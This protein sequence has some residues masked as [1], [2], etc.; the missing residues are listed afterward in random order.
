M[1]SKLIFTAAIAY[2]LWLFEAKSQSLN[3][4][5]S[6]TDK[7]EVNNDVQ[8]VSSNG[9]DRLVVVGSGTVNKSVDLKD[10]NSNQKTNEFGFIAV[11]DQDA[12][13]KWMHPAASPNTFTTSAWGVLMNA[14][15][16]VFVYGVYG[17]SNTDFDPGP[18]EVKPAAS[19]YGDVY[20][21]KF[22]SAGVFQ[23]VAQIGNG[24]KPQKM[25]QL[26]NGNLLVSGY[27]LDSAVVTI[28]STPIN[29]KAGIFLAEVSSSGALVKVVSGAAPVPSN[30]SV[31]GLAQD[32]TGNIIIGGSFDSW[33][34][35]DFGPGFSYDTTVTAID[36]F[37][38]KYNSSYEL[39]WQKR[40]GDTLTT[41][42]KGWDR[43]RS[44]VTDASGNIYVNGHFTW[45]TDFDPDANPGVHLLT[46]SRNSPMPNG[47]LMKYNSAGE[48]QWVKQIGRMS[49]TVNNDTYLDHLKLFGG[50]LIMAGTYSNRIDI[51][52]DPVDT[53]VLRAYDG[54]GSALFFAK[55]DTDGKFQEGFSIDDT[56]ASQ[57]AMT[58]ESI[59]GICWLNGKLCAAGLFQ[60]GVDF[61][62]G[63]G[64]RILYCDPTGTLYNFDKD[65]YVA[66]FNFAGGSSGV[67]EI[68]TRNHAL[69]FPNPASDYFKIANENIRPTSVSLL[70][71]DGKLIFELPGNQEV[72]PAEGLKPGIY[73]VLLQTD[74]GMTTHKLI[75]R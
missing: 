13:L 8:G 14:S 49:P 66:S 67:S 63:P 50:N 51:N 72:Y 74:N 62:P 6:I 2:F 29:L 10:P 34:D 1:K 38:A 37:V 16:E 33:T 41:N 53:F 71:I 56:V 47:F 21:Q 68:S 23:W 35:F 44:I 24:G 40:F 43:V 26:S 69:L 15:S 61:D 60:K 52:T 46:S 54:N 27:M 55:Y 20:I 36:A 59:A 25:I 11:Y 3:W 39:Q 73:Q 9:I 17:G 12:N 5:Y 57:F 7:N 70:S 31:V 75:I 42:P 4:A 22:N 30:C 45:T 18:A 64:M 28:G 58:G 65:I 19:V 32:A 48:L